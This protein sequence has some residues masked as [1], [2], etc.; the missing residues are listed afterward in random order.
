MSQHMRSIE[1]AHLGKGTDGT[2]PLNCLLAPTNL[3]DK[4]FC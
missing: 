2:C 3:F 1:L 4:V